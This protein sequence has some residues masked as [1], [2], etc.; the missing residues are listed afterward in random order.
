[1]KSLPGELKAS[2]FE[3]ELRHNLWAKDCAPLLIGLFNCSLDRSEYFPRVT[4][5][6]MTLEHCVRESSMQLWMNVVEHLKSLSAVP[7]ISNLGLYLVERMSSL[8]R[9]WKS[10]N[11]KN[12]L[13]CCLFLIAVEMEVDHYCGCEGHVLQS[14]NLPHSLNIIALKDH[15]AVSPPFFHTSSLQKISNDETCKYFMRTCF[16]R[17]GSFTCSHCCC[18]SAMANGAVRLSITRMYNIHM[19]KT[20]TQTEKHP[21]PML[22]WIL[23]GIQTHL[24][25]RLPPTQKQ[26]AWKPH[27]LQATGLTA[28]QTETKNWNCLK[29]CPKT[30]FTKDEKRSKGISFMRGMVTK[31]MQVLFTPKFSFPLYLLLMKIKGFSHDELRPVTNTF[32]DWYVSYFISGSS[33]SFVLETFWY[34][35]IDF[36]NQLINSQDGVECKCRQRTGYSPHHGFQGIQCLLYLVVLNLFIGSI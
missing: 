24:K 10:S 25:Q 2:Q 1:M 35:L 32:Y 16:S 6:S 17:N 15:S 21:Q 18:V 23:H 3:A 27:K 30:T 34:W 22:L 13:N 7:T 5:H 9:T 26:L 14:E 12:W 33:E 19:K 8:K 28:Q 11:Q 36:V 4:Q 31:L 29:N 20:T